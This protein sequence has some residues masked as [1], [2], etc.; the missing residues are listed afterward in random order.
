[1]R[2]GRAVLSRFGRYVRDH[3]VGLLALVIAMSGT[4]YAATA[5]PKNSVGRKQLRNNAVTSKK[6]KNRSLLRRDLAPGVIPRSR[7]GGPGGRGPRGFRGPR[8]RRGLRGLTGVV[9]NVT[10]QRLDLPL[11]DNSNV[12]GSVPCPSGQKIL[13]GSANVADTTSADVNI[14]VS[15][16]AQGAGQLLPTSGQAFDRWRAAAVNPAGGTGATTLRVWAICAP[17]TQPAVPTGGAGGD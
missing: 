9:G 4:A 15:R 6:V 16:P 5:L 10:V 17:G 12:N 11:A 1:M 2:Y 13:A 14:T 3:H 8:G 7:R